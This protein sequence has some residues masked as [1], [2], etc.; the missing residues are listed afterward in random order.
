MFRYRKVSMLRSQK[1]IMLMSLCSGLEMCP[2]GENVYV[3][4]GECVGILKDEY[5]QVSKSVCAGLERYSK[6]ES[7]LVPKG[8]Y[9]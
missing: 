1:V 5:L 3:P 7:V 4:K 8:D 6:I 9:V 2:K